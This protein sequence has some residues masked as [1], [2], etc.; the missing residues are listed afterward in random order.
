[1][2][3]KD[4]TLLRSIQVS[5]I[6]GGV[7]GEMVVPPPPPKLRF[8]EH[9]PLVGLTV[10]HWKHLGSGRKVRTYTC[11]LVNNTPQRPTQPNPNG[12]NLPSSNLSS[13]F[14][15]FKYDLN[16]SFSLNRCHFPPLV[17]L[18]LLLFY[19]PSVA[20]TETEL[21]FLLLLFASTCADLGFWICSKA[22]YIAA[23]FQA[24]LGGIT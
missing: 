21:L 1:M 15:F 11:M 24:V 4:Q 17:R 10:L 8:S 2:P 19:Y 13:I 22:G 16:L 7:G 20:V 18:E 3:C 5:E 12:F 9:D 23:L 14:F 6:Q